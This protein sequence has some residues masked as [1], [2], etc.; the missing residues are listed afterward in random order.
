MQAGRS[1]KHFGSKRVLREGT[2]APTSQRAP[3]RG[4]PLMYA[5]WIGWMIAGTM[6]HVCREWKKKLFCGRNAK[7]CVCTPRIGLRPGSGPSF[8]RSRCG[9]QTHSAQGE[10]FYHAI[11]SCF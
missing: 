9:C 1:P 4:T 8:G 10:S 6:G 2:A 11:S 5:A 3:M 7:L